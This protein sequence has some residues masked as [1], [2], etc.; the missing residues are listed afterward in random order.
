MSTMTRIG[1]GVAATG[2]AG[3]MSLGFATSAFADHI[4]PPM[5]NEA[6]QAEN[7]VDYVEAHGYENVECTKLN[8]G[9]DGDSWESDS[10]YVL[11]ALKAGS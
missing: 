5:G 9:W 11:V 10:D 4:D 7:W 1:R 2:V 6:N 8:D 3:L